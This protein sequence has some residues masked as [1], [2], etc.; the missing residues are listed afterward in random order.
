MEE[1]QSVQM[2]EPLEQAQPEEEEPLEELDDDEPEEEPLEPE[3]ELEEEVLLVGKHI[4]P[5]PLPKESKNAGWQ[6]APC[7]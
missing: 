7:F 1:V 3:E 2:R 4:Q 5:Q 6:I